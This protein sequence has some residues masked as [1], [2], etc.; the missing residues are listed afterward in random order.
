MRRT[1]LF[2]GRTP[3]TRRVGGVSLIVCSS[4]D[5]VFTGF[6]DFGANQMLGWIWRP[7]GAIFLRRLDNRFYQG[8]GHGGCC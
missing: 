6:G 4:D 1:R 2:C 8:A 5:Q 3:Y 7:S